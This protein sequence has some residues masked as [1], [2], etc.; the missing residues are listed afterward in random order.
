MILALSLAFLVLWPVT[1]RDKFMFPV[2]GGQGAGE[3]SGLASPVSNGL[4][5]GPS[6]GT[7]VSAWSG[8][9]RLEPQWHTDDIVLRERP[10]WASRPYIHLAWYQP[11]S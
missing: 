1:V 3:A 5:V 2:T 9:V 4:E 6:G 10:V 7:A 11:L 8:L